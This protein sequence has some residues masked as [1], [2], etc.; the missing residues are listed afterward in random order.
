MHNTLTHCHGVEFSRLYT[1]TI[2]DNNL[3]YYH[4]H[5]SQ[6]W[7]SITFLIEAGLLQHDN[8]LPSLYR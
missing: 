1:S 5:E 2:I 6:R 7:L 3:I 4:V 8:M